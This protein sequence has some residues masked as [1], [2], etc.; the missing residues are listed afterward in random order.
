MGL[1]VIVA[2][3][4]VQVHSRT[5][6]TSQSAGNPEG[7]ILTVTIDRVVSGVLALCAVVMTA[8]VVRR[9]FRGPAR[10]R[11][12]PEQPPKY[13]PE[14]RDALPMAFGSDSSNAPVIVIEFIDFEC[15]ICARYDPTLQTLRASRA[16][17]VTVKYVHFP[18]PQH[19]FARPAAHAVE[20]AHSIGQ[21]HEFV[22]VL[23]EKQ[24]SLGL[25]SWESYGIEA[26]IA[27]MPKLKQC[28]DHSAPPVR[29]D[30]GVR[31]GERLGVSSTPTLLVNGWMLNGGSWSVARLEALIDGLRTGALGPSS[32]A[33]LIAEAGSR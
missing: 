18:L 27:D 21:G 25:K 32:S 19:R 12:V 23:F 31:L 7:D 14:W 16:G 6:R 26:G 5:D 11:T 17:D 20:C 30:A 28:L 9:E 33:K 22:R 15:P 8:S 2:W 1:E 4:A 29:I 24:D 13:I 3:R 10:P